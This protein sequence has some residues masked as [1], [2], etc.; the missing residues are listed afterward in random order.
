LNNTQKVAKFATLHVTDMGPIILPA[1]KQVMFIDRRAICHSE[2]NMNT[3]LT[4]AIKHAIRNTELAMIHIITIS[5][6]SWGQRENATETAVYCHRSGNVT[7]YEGK[8]ENKVPYFIA[9]K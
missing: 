5:G 4:N 6:F 2:N 8:S 7:L 1:H 9:T 3:L